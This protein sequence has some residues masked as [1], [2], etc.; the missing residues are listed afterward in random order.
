MITRA[1][2]GFVLAGAL[3]LASRR[4]RSLSPS[5][6]LAALGIGTAAAVA[7]W[8]W[9]ILLIVFF[10]LSSALSRFRRATRE[11]RIGGIVEKGDERDA[12]Q[13]LANGGVFAIAA[14]LAG[15]TGQPLWGVAALGALAA[16]AGDT[17]ATEIGTL[18]GGVPRSI[19][20]LKPL[21]PGTSGGITVAGTLASVVGS[22]LVVAV[23]H[24]T[25]VGASP[26]AVFL[27]GVAGSLADSLAG[28]TV[29]ER[30]WCDACERL[31]E[32]RVHSCG[33][34]TRVVGGVAGIRNDFVNVVCTI[35]GASVAMIVAR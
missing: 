17:W 25:G 26:G 6:A 10:V 29:Q 33:K 20:S 12:Y 34:V 3:A 18:F 16:A 28:A 19:V 8:G 11:A 1:L 5:G 9:A 21:P 13:V 30:R 7:G 2:A 27:G 32:R 22:T 14:L 31:T 15:S 23:A 4:A 35:V 24:L